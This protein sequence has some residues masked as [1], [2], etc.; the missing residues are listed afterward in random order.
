MVTKSNR[1]CPKCGERIIYLKQK[2]DFV[3][4]ATGYT[5]CGAQRS[6]MKRD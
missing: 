1:K 3:H 5:Q 6:V 2:K 4:F